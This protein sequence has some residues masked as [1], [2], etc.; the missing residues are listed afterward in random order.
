[1]KLEIK[2]PYCKN[3]LT[4]EVDTDETP[5]RGSLTEDCPHCGVEVDI[6]RLAFFA[7]ERE[8][9]AGERPA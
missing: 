7:L 3:P 9:A 1:M 6:I 5:I 2:C 4:T 8:C